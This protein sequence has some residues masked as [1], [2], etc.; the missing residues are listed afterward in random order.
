[1][2]EIKTA[3]LF[4]V[5]TALLIFIGYE[6]AG[7]GGV[8]MALIVAAG[9]NF[10]SYWWSDKIVLRQ[11]RAQELS[12]GQA[13]ELFQMI[14]EITRRD[15]L[16]MPRVYVVPDPSPNAFATGRNPEHAAVAVTEGI[17][18]LLNYQELKGVIG[19]ELSHVKHRDTLITTV[20]A[21]IAGAMSMLSS[22]AMWGGM[23]ARSRDDRDRGNPILGLIGIMMAPIAAAVIQMAISRSREF[24][25][26]ESGAEVSGDPRALASALLKIESISQQVPI[27][28]G[29]P[30]TGSLFIINPFSGG[31]A[32]LFSTHPPTTERVQRLEALAR[33]LGLPGIG[34]PRLTY[35]R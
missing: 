28:G 15:N 22:M 3:M 20:A 16:P 12:P 1:M 32:R 30:A 27:S 26:D 2:N 23:A 25:A 11:Y 13:P 19:H 33:Q 31:L 9:V 7:Q 5:L 14:G 35:P 8:M 29:S 10:A 24:S 6:L 18:R 17:V 4:A 34:S 21:T